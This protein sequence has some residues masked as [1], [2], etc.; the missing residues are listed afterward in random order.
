VGGWKSWDGLAKNGVARPP[1]FWPM[2]VWSHPLRPVWGWSNHPHGQGVGPANPKSPSPQN[3]KQ[4]MGFGLLGVAGPPFWPWGWFN[5]PQTG[6][7]GGSSHPLA[8]NG[9]AR[10]TPLGQ[11]TPRFPSLFFWG[12]GGFWGWPDHPLAMGVVRPPSDR[13]WG[14]L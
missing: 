6:R 2:G 9:V 1:H 3:K 7:G 11:A 8:K 12:G 5:H 10:A 14:W 13:P 4:S